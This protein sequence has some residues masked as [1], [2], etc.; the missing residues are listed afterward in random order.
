MEISDTDRFKRRRIH[1][2]DLHPER[3]DARTG[4][5]FL[6]RVDG[7]LNTEQI[8][9]IELGLSYDLTL[10]CL[11]EIEAAL[12]EVG[13]HLDNGLLFRIQRALHYYTE[14]TCRENCGC[15]RGYNNCSKRVFAMRYEALEHGCRDRRPEHWRR[16]L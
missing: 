3:N 11:K 5:E 15:E 10:T 1:F 12:D 2:R 7:V 9:A 6:D 14:D 16:Y 8:T 4:A 13:L